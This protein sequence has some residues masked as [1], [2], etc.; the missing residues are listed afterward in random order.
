MI[1]GSKLATRETAV[2]NGV[3]CGVPRAKVFE[4]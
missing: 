2:G 3:R 1:K 4:I